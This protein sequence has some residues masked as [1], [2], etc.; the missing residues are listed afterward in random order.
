MGTFKPPRNNLS[1]VRVIGQKIVLEG[2]SFSFAVYKVQTTAGKI[3]ERL[4]VRHPGC[5]VII[6]YMDGYLYLVRQYR[7][8]TGESL[9]ELPAGTIEQGEEP[10]ECAKR[11]LKEETGLE[12]LNIREIFTAYLAPGYSSEE[13]HFFL[14]TRL[15]N[16]GGE[17]EEDEE[18]EV[19][20]M[21]VEEAYSM[22]FNG[23]FKD[24]K[25]ML[26]ILWLR[27]R[28]QAAQLA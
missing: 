9:I 23:S 15:R 12:A 26:G 8:A 19:V 27:S 1:D 10:L 28:L 25:T 18:I 13:A 14:A 20:R 11:E 2:K 6:P 4:V 22:V 16:T 7:A 5:V 17:P 3:V 24:A 21:R